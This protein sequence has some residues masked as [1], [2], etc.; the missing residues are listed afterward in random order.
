MP[1]DFADIV[2][3]P[4]PQTMATRDEPPFV[5]QAATPL[6]VDPASRR[7][8]EL[9]A[10]ALAP[11]TGW[12]LAVVEQGD[13]VPA[14]RLSVDPTLGELGQE[15]YVLT[16]GP[17]GVVIRAATP[18]GIFYGTQT[19][20]QLLPHDIFSSAPL[21]RAWTIPALSI[22]DRPRFSWRG[23]MLDVVRHFSAP[24]EIYK[25]LDLLALHKQNVLHLHLTDDQGWRIEIK[26]YPRLTE[27]GGWRKETVIG[28]ARLPQGYDGTPHSGYYTQEDLR[29]IVA[30]AA[31]RF[32]T[33]V[34]EIDLPGHANAAVAAYPELGVTGEPIEVGTTW[35]VFPHLFNPEEKALDALRQIF[36]EMLAI[37]PSPF[38]HVGGDEAIKTQWQQSPRVQERIKELGLQN[39]DELQ[40]WFLSQIGAFL[41]QNG[42][43]MVGWD[44]I[45]EGGLPAG[46]TV[47]SWR[48]EAGG[49]AAAQAGHDVVMTPGHPVYLD[50]YQTNDPNE[51]LNIHGY[52]PLD[53]VYAYQ[54]VPAE[55]TPEQARHVLGSQGNLWSEYITEP[56]F[57][58][59]MLFPRLLALGE[60]TWTDPQ[61]R[62]FAGFRS[63]LSQHEVRLDHLGVTYRPVALWDLE[64]SFP[65]RKQPWE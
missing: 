34:P 59:Y 2:L 7:V 16:S 55:L 64:A 46:A 30:Y 3:I 17:D 38:I 24:E 56:A 20:R 21:E 49:I 54:P 28:H 36:A 5:L 27:T 62:D 31:E 50:N 22:E 11:A 44:E 1:N 58:E 63:R 45:L 8:G 41:A 60:V 51:R 61:P 14:I 15:G 33:V 25:L 40:S 29:A 19:L 6:V 48:G 57:L 4:L 47:M 32:I 37:F 12:R 13:R 35:G 65:T 26:S 43:R 39:E 52:N 18:A 10:A 23:L 53:A 42:R 9:L